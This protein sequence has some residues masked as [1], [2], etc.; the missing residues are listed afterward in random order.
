M[1]VIVSKWFWQTQRKEFLSPTLRSQIFS[2]LQIVHLFQ[3]LGLLL[4]ELLLIVVL[5]GSCNAIEK[6]ASLLCVAEVVDDGEEEETEACGA[7]HG[8]DA[9]HDPLRRRAQAIIVV[10]SR[11][12]RSVSERS[13]EGVC[14]LGDHGSGG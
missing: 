1:L 6:H 13:F 3:R 10:V 12:P 4:G 9:N 11:Y 7:K 2:S 5:S 8:E 14:S